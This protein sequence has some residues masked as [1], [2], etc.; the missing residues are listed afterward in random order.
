MKNFSIFLFVLILLLALP[1]CG[2][3]SAA[4]SQT[5]LATVPPEFAGVKNPFGSEAST[6]GAEIFKT[7]CATCHGDKG[8]GDGSAGIYLDP[9]PANL[10]VLNTAVADDY[11]YWRISTGRDGT[12]MPAWKGVLDDQQI[13]QVIAFIRTLK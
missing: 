9:R 5:P 11:L 13:W 10:A 1:A 8:L 2:N 12:A 7:N 4:N 3:Y 6:A